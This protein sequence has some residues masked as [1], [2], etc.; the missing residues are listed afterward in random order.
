MTLENTRAALS[1]L[2]YS[3]EGVGWLVRKISAVLA[4]YSSPA[5]AARLFEATFPTCG[6][7]RFEE[8]DFRRFLKD[9][10][11]GNHPFINLTPL[12]P[13]EMDAMEWSEIEA[14]KKLCASP[15]RDF[16]SL[17]QLERYQA[18]CSR[19][20]RRSKR[21]EVEAKHLPTAR[22]TSVPVGG[23]RRKS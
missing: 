6:L 7:A 20:F 14:H 10:D 11:P 21:D 12:S 18:L 15:P 17:A 1:K 3:A 2:G 19:H 16:D 9:I 8:S 5:E 23:K 13:E 22:F 4:R